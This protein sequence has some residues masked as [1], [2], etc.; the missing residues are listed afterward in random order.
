MGVGGGQ[1]SGTDRTPRAGRSG[2]PRENTRKLELTITL[3]DSSKRGALFGS[4]DRHLRL[5]RGAFGV[6]IS[7]RDS[8]IKLAGNAQAVGAAATVI[9]DLQR[10]LKDRDEESA[11]HLAAYRSALDLLGQRYSAGSEMS[12]GVSP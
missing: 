3:D 10:L 6:Q 5:I 11:K 9:E 12:S 2:R 7:A 4:A 8:T 1:P